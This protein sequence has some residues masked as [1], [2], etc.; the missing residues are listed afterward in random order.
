MNRLILA[1]KSPRRLELLETAFAD[2][3][4]SDYKLEV[5][6]S[7]KK[8]PTPATGECPEFYTKLLARMKAKAVFEQIKDALAPDDVVLGADTAVYCSGKI[9]GQP[10]DDSDAIRMLSEMSGQPQE[11]VTGV[12]LMFGD[13]R[14]HEFSERTKLEVSAMSDAQIAEY[15]ASGESTGRAG[16][17]AIGE[18]A[19]EFVSIKQG[20]MS[21]CVGLP[22]ER[23]AEELGNF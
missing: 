23:L 3:V 9:I 1:S 5:N 20:S 13:G 14:T 8:E 6:P 21:N 19:D 22:V 4:I 17:Y 7:G 2:G 16:A 18:T 11:V 12:A 15:V 10:V